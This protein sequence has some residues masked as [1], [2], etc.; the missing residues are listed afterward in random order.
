MRGTLLE[1][2]SF[3]FLFVERY[4]MSN[5]LFFY[6]KKIYKGNTLDLKYYDLSIMW[7][8]RGR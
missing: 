1:S 4:E 8:K 5:F 7:G 2:H 6:S 3:T